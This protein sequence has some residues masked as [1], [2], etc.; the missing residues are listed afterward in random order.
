M[1]T[2]ACIAALTVDLPIM[3]CEAERQVFTKSRYEKDAARVREGVALENA[4]C[5]ITH[6]QGCYDW[7]AVR[8][9]EAD[10]R[11]WEVRCAAAEVA[12][13]ACVEKLKLLSQS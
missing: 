12:L 5:E 3:S 7:A 13:A 9:A 10:V 1:C 11:L 8:R 4:L 2:G 6:I